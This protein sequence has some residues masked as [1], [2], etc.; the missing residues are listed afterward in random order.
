MVMNDS[1]QPTADLPLGE[2]VGWGEDG[3]PRAGMR[4][5]GYSLV[6]PLGRGGMGVVW[7]A[8]QLEPIRRQVAIKLIRAELAAPA[9]MT[10][11]RAERQALA[12]MSHPNVAKVF[13]AGATDAGVPYFVMEF[14]DG[15]PVTAYCD[16]HRLSVPERLELFSIICDAVHHAH[17]KGVIHRDIKPENVL[18]SRRDESAR[19]THHPMVIDFGIAKA[20]SET[21]STDSGRTAIGSFIG[22][23][24]YMSP[25]QAEGSDDVDVQS[26]VYSLG[27]LL[28]ELLVGSPPFDVTRFQGCSPV[29]CRRI[30]CDETPPTPSVRAA[31]IATDAASAARA[32][33]HHA[34]P[35]AEARRTTGPDLR[36]LLHRELEWIPMRAMRKERSRR[37]RSAAELGDDVRNYL[38]GRPLIAGPESASYRLRKFAARHRVLLAAGAF[39]LVALVGGL[40]LSERSAREARRERDRAESLAVFFAEHVLGSVAERGQ[41][42]RTPVGSLLQDVEAEVVREAA[43]ATA[44]LDRRDSQL[45]MAE[46]ARIYNRMHLREAAARTA[47]AA[48]AL[49]ADADDDDDARAT[50][51][52]ELIEALFKIGSEASLAESIDLAESRVRLLEE[53]GVDEE[54]ILVSMNLLAG[55]LKARGSEES[56]ARAA[57]IYEEVAARRQALLGPRHLDTLIA[58]YNAILVRTARGER[59]A[60][61]GDDDGARRIFLETLPL[62]DHVAND[63]ARAAA[64]REDAA[65]SERDRA[66]LARRTLIFREEYARQL[67]RLGRLEP[68]RY[69]EALILYDQ[70]IPDMERVFGGRGDAFGMARASRAALFERIGRQAEAFEEYASAS[71]ILADALGPEQRTSWEV[72]RR[73]AALASHARSLAP[74]EA[75][76]RAL[77][78]ECGARAECPLSEAQRSEAAEWARFAGADELA[79]EL[80]EMRAAPASGRR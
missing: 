30:V 62:Y 55:A 25:E 11:F 46:L 58:R 50:A 79:T 13:D 68:E 5:R 33:N 63:A 4:I 54:E 9:I 78:D 70:L 2:S 47:R 59:L 22:T 57:S 48:L 61:E 27:V 76:L 10:R 66:A 45:F 1:P 43:A 8:D 77:A 16:H 74:L 3:A 28:Y 64:D 37:Y 31:A 7:L 26:D 44:P 56:L 52:R 39:A 24:A 40:V 20:L 53:D 6:R 69:P 14:V 36:R 34:S 60:R 15:W 32:G 42:A 38:A 21:A 41:G 65:R 35:I 67:V 17:A 51:E 12:L 19:A 49:G 72:L 73:C 18:V 71:S 23:P 29:E 80:E 75:R